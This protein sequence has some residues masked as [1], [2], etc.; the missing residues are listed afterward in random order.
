MEGPEDLIASVPHV[1]GFHPRDSLVVMAMQQSSL[2]FTLRVDIPLARHRRGLAEQLLMPIR[3]QQPTS[4]LLMVFG[5]GKAD[6]AGKPPHAK[7]IDLMHSALCSVGVPLAHAIWVR[8]CQAGE[9]WICYADPECSGTMP[10]PNTS[11]LAAASA[12][13]GNVTFA[14]RSDVVAL[15]EPVGDDVLTRRSELLDKAVDEHQKETAAGIRLVRDTIG[16]DTPLSD[17]EVVAL[18]MALSDHRVR[19]ACMTYAIGDKSQAAERLWLELTRGCPAPERAEPA[20]LLAVNAYLR[21]DGG[22]ASVAIEAAEAACPGHRLA[23]LLRSAFDCGLAPARIRDLVLGA[24]DE[25]AWLLR[26]GDEE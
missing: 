22:L 15:V 23:G 25:A 20:T 16:R 11:P 5:G 2:T 26:S 19:D 13:A 7:L 14:D 3:A 17:D 10:D 12:A 24:A 6:P 1:L 18:A 8:S 4:V 21:G 9:P